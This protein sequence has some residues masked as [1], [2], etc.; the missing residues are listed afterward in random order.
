MSQPTTGVLGTDIVNYAR[1]QLGDPYI[2]GAE[3][4]DEFDCSGLVD[5]VYRHFGL[6]TPRT[7]ADMLANK[8]GLQAI[9][10]AQLQPGD[11]ILS[12]GWLRDNPNQGHVGIY[13]GGGRLVEAGDP[14]QVTTFGPNYRAHVTG[15][16]RVPGVAGYGGP[17]GDATPPPGG[18]TGGLPNPTNPGQVVGFVRSWIPT[19]GNITEGLTNLGE[20]MLGV[21]K[22]A[23]EIGQLAGSVSRLFLPSN[24][25]RAFLL[26]SG[27][28][29]VLIGVWFIASEAKDV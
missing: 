2:W 24:L 22:G 3:G 19:P 23:V 14:V 16:R 7:T 1:T 27:F 12:K 18:Y 17:G 9:T 4:P 10:E 26:M 28:L 13:A 21:A 5:Y 11:L 29:F 8:G 25:L 15:Y 20:A 6:T